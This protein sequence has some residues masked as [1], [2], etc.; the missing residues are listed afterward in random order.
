MVNPTNRVVNPTNVLRGG[1]WLGTARFCL[2]VYSNRD[3]P[4]V[5][6][7]LYGFRIVKGIKDEKDS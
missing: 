6:G 1:S 4:S 2:F 7:R 5:W 3:E